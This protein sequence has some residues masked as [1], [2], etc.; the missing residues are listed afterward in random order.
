MRILKYTMTVVIAVTLMFVSLPYAHAQLDIQWQTGFQ[1]QNLS[2]TSPAQID[3]TFYRQDGTT[4]PP[5]QDTIPG[6]GSK[7]YFPLDGSTGPNVGTAFNGSAIISSNQPVAA[8]LN[9][10]GNN[11]AYLGSAMGLD[12][13]SQ[14]VGLPLIQKGN[15]GYET[16]F[17]VQNAGSAPAN[18]T[19]N[20]TPGLAGSAATR[21]ATIPPGASATF[22]TSQIAELGTRFV[23]SATITSN[24]PVVSM[25]NQTGLGQFRNVLMYEG[26]SAAD[27]A[28]DLRLPLIQNAN[29]GFFTGI[30]V[31]NT[32]SQPAQVTL[33]YGPNTVQGATPPAPRQFTLQPGAAETILQNAPTEMGTGRYVGSATLTSNQPLVAVVNQ[34]RAGANVGSA[35][36]GTS[37]TAATQRVSAPLLM[38]N[39]GGFFSAIQCQNVGNAPTNLTI[40]YSANTA[41]G[42]TYRPADQTISNVPAGETRIF[43]QSPSA[44][45]TTNRYVG[46]ATITS[47]A[48]PIV[49]IVNQVNLASPD[50]AFSSYFARN[51]D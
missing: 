7:T 8:I 27:G 39:N 2:T 35:Y 32:G 22:D 12:S 30:N 17:A 23:G 48:T 11:F 49:C 26:F 6:G 31:Q 21:T 43:D 34:I 9:L 38:T 24:Q 14:T 16:W 25:V 45:N 50:D 13:G 40:T 20:F 47:S 36:E 41:P 4:L 15:A 10:S 3:V 18:V 28:T 1:V 51:F 33:T 42:Q 29:A 5:F 44:L 19:I 46:G 37:A